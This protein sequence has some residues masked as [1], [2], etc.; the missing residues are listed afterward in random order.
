[1]QVS[2]PNNVKIYNL[3]AGKSLP[4][5]LSARKKQKAAKKKSGEYRRHIELIQDFDMPALSNNVR[6]SPDGQYILATGIYK[7]RVKCYDVNQLSI[8]FERCFDSEVINFEILSDDYSKVVF[9]QCDRF[10]DPEV[11]RLNLERGQ[12]LAPLVTEASEIESLTINSQHHLLLLGTKEG[13]VEAWDPRS[14]T[15]AGR[16][17]CAL[18]CAE[19]IKDQDVAFPSVSALRCKDGLVFGAG[20]ASGQVLLFDLRSSRPL[21]VKDHMYGLP[22]K[23]LDFHIPQNLTL[24]LDA[25]VLKLW[26]CQTGKIF[27]SIEPAVEMNQFSLIP[28]TGMMFIANENPKI[29][30]YYIPSLGPAPKWC[31][32]LDSLTEELEESD[33]QN[34]YDDYKFVT[35]NEVEELGL[36]HLVEEGMES[37]GGSSLEDSS[38]DD[39]H[40]WTKE[41]KK[42]HRMLRMEAQQREREEVAKATSQPRM[43]E[44]RPGEE[45]TLG[46][47]VRLEDNN[48]VTVMGSGGSREMK[49]TMKKMGKEIRARE[50]ARKHREERRQLQRPTKGLHTRSKSAPSGGW[51]SK[52]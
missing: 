18:S 2:D 39:E 32:F 19:Y 44:L 51:R 42:Q 34:I 52:R 14:K 1:M 15:C 38:S 6:I 7:P 28:D 9:L 11:Y 29:L 26:N 50:A 8:K 45:A 21:I 17:D 37:E 33:M 16:L 36:G 22:I 25:S 23:D 20:T 12:F 4:D 3:S 31:S 24:S 35:T 27:T 13:R 46:D 48:E 10:I 47:R 41:V 43:F 30:T 5:W 49:F 40:Q